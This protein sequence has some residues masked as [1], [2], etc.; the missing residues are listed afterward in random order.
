MK[1]KQKNLCPV[2]LT[3]HRL[4]QQ[5]SKWFQTEETQ[6]AVQETLYEMY[7]CVDCG[8]WHRSKEPLRLVTP[9]TQ[10]KF[11]GEIDK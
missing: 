3:N 1:N 4:T 8:T 9:I 10:W 5:N 11:K 2:S 6:Y 7:R